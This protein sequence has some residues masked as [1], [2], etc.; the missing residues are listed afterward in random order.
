M[1]STWKGL[2]GTI[3]LVCLGGLALAAP[4]PTSS[5][6]L[7]VVPPSLGSATPA[8]GGLN[9]PGLRD[10]DDA[11]GRDPTDTPPPVFY[12][13]ELPLDHEAIV[14]VIDRSCSMS[15]KTGE[16]VDENEAIQKG[17][18]RLDRAKAELKRSIKSLPENFKFN[19]VIFGSCVETLWSEVRAADPSNKKLAMAWADTIKTQGWTNA[20]L[21]TQTALADKSVKSVVLLSDGSPNY[22]DCAELLEKSPTFHREMIRAANTQG[23]QIHTFGVDPTANARAFLQG[24]AADSGGT[25][26]EVR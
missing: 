5:M 13:E 17:G 21:A 23:A 19:V 16:Y 18:S 1:V 4:E 25:Y 24:V 20:G 12:G 10:F 11:D 2:L 15:W 9:G 3:S 7:P 22:I 8:A 6:D 26:S 14:Y